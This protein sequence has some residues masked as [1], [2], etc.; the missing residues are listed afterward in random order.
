MPGWGPGS[1][2]TGAKNTG[3]KWCPPGR[4]GAPRPYESAGGAGSWATRR[5]PQNGKNTTTVPKE[6]ARRTDGIGGAL[7]FLRPSPLNPGR[8][9]VDLFPPVSLSWGKVK[10][11][12]CRRP[13][14]PPVFRL[15]RLR[16]LC[17]PSSL[18]PVQERWGIYEE[19]GVGK[20]RRPF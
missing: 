14:P 19:L 20:R 13:C 3:G 15:N 5:L 2:A 4:A 9:T 18:L 1:R 7:W 10:V 12:K 6:I 11:G 17:G 16:L 8:G